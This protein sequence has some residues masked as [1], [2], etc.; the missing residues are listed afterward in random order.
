MGVKRMDERDIFGMTLEPVP[1]DPSKCRPLFGPERKTVR[2]VW[3]DVGSPLDIKGTVALW[4][5]TGA[6]STGSVFQA[7]VDGQRYENFASHRASDLALE[8]GLEPSHFE[9][10][11]PSG[12][13]GYTVDDVREVADLIARV[14]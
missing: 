9:G 3:S 5:W 12:K 1:G 8:L 11:T 2:E 10:V 6:E 7:S 4:E 13:T 14:T